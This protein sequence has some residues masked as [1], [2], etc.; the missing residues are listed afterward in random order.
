[1]M[2]YPVY[3]L[4]VMLSTSHGTSVERINDFNNRGD[5]ETAGVVFTE[6]ANRTYTVYSGSATYVCLEDKKLQNR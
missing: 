1:M 2:Q 4:V 3:I 5:C 6:K